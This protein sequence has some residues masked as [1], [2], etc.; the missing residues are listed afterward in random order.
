MNGYISLRNKILT[1]LKNELPDYLHYHGIHHTLDVLKVC[2]VYVRREKIKSHQAKL[3]RLTVLLHDIGFV[4]DEENHEE[5]G[6]EIAKELLAEFNFSKRDIGKVQNMI[7]A[8]KIPQ[9]PQNELEKIICDVDLDYLGRS[10][11]HPISELLF[12]ELKERGKISTKMDWIKMQIDFLR[13]HKFHTSFA[14]KNREPEK[15]RR[16]KELE[17]IL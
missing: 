12:S 13:M 5:A 7:L 3:L 15:Q 11:Y 2:N 4:R 6:V 17:E 9:N 8:T 14:K 10:D 1:I 16:I